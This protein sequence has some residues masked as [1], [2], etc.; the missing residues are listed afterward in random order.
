V[1]LSTRQRRALDAICDTFAPGSAARG[2]PEGMLQVVE[3]NPRT[4]EQAQVG[5]LL[6]LFALRRFAALP[7]ERREA[8]LRGW[9]DSRIPQRRAAFQALRKGVTHMDARALYDAVGY[10]GALGPPVHPAP[11][12]IVSLEVAADATLDCDVCVVGSGAGGATAA[13]VLAAAGLDVIVLEAGAHYDDADFDGAEHAGWRRLYEQAGAAATNDQSVGLLAGSC[14]GG[15]TVVNYTTSFRTPDEVRAEWAADGVPAFT[16][17]A[18]T[19]SLDAV[20]ER[21]GVNVDNNRVS[22]REAVFRRGL[23][24]L[25]W[26]CEAMSR[27]VVDCDQDGPECG[28]CGF[29]C[30]RGAKQSTLKTWLVDAHAA[31][32]RILVR[33]RARRVLVDGGVTRGVEAETADGHSVTVRARAV[34]AACG[35]IQTPALL[36]RSGLGNRQI[37]RNLRLHPVTGV[38][39]L[40]DDDVRPWE[41]TMQAVYSDEHRD[42]DGTGYG[43][44]YE[45]APVHPTLFAAFLPW[46]TAAQHAELASALRHVSLVGVLLR[47]RSAGEVRVGRDG[48]PVSRYALSE[49]DVRHVRI[50]LDGGARILEAAGAKKIVSAHARGVSYEPGRTSR[51]QFMHDADA[52]GYGAGRCVFYSFHLMG[53]AR[54]GG[55][56]ATSACGPEGETWDVRNL[57]VCDGST[58][59]SA[60]GVNPMISIEAI[61]HMNARALASRLA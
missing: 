25:G 26:H 41:G 44:K 40:F 11:R 8:V 45:T 50:G 46:R 49:Q 37:G 52:C 60:S 31:G 23:D 36:R 15:S 27:N 28:W 21:L 56:A 3:A 48:E 7:Q 4:A 12:A 29:G 24:A 9:C 51:E 38:F 34:V 16:S 20:C 58:F 53:S 10:P 55:T 57:V 42:L 30:R 14:L 43:V 35:A 1:D 59:P 17:D 5:L 54:M 61:A 47:D 19:D 32:A 6:S 39:G 13:A 33:T 2:A 18:Y 22:A